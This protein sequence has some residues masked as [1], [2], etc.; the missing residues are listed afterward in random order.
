MNESKGSE[1]HT[2]SENITTNI[3]FLGSGEIFSRVIAY[4]GVTY[5][6]VRLGPEGFGII[7]FATT[8]YW[9]FALGVAGGI[10]FIGSQEIARQPHKT[11]SIIANILIYRI[12]IAF[13]LLGLIG[14]L[15]NSLDKTT[16][17]KMV[18]F[19]TGLLL[20]PLAFDTSWVY[21]GLQKSKPVAL[22]QILNQVL[23][24]VGLIWLVNS[25]P[26]VKFIPLVQLFAET[27]TVLILIIPFIGFIKSRINLR[28]GLKIVQRASFRTFSL[29]MKTITLTFDMI[30]IGFLLGEK[31]LGLYNAPYRICFLL[32]ALSNAIHA[33]YLPIFSKETDK[34]KIVQTAN[35]SLY[36]AVTIIA[37]ISFGGIFVSGLIIEKLFGIEY[38]DGQNALQ[39]LLLSSFF[40]FIQGTIHNVFLTIDRLKTELIILSVAAFINIGLNIFIIPIYGITGAALVTALTELLIVFLSLITLAKFGYFVTFYIIWKP[41]L[42]SIVM[43]LILFISGANQNLIMSLLIGSVSYVVILKLFRGIPDETYQFLNSF[44][45]NKNKRF[46]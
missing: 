8:I 2:L 4:I 18:I 43:I 40:I 39:L 24:V 15:T 10:N 46:S 23:Y 45:E 42:A 30:L 37:P 12:I 6:A 22:T 33:V 17:I 19:L 34:S 9:Y 3:F 11:N 29:L 28:E 26:D 5:L 38:S 32:M 41:I 27:V 13:I 7:S 16:S 21:Y 35:N 14:L 36:L 31:S 44:S 20:I 1:N 25:P